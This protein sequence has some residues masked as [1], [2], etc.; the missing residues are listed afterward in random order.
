MELSEFIGVG[1][2][3]VAKS[4]GNPHKNTPQSSKENRM[5]LIRVAFLNSDMGASS[6]PSPSSMSGSFVSLD[7]S[8][9]SLE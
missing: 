7:N 1:G 3:Q 8:F 6:P 9:S 2:L 5:E 4:Q